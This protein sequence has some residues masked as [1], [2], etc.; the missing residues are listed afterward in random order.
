VRD[1]VGLNPQLAAASGA[2]GGQ[3]LNPDVIFPGQEITLPAASG[4]NIYSGGMGTNADTMAQIGRGNMPDSAITQRMA[5]RE[6]LKFV[7]LPVDRLI[8]RELTAMSWVVNES[9]YNTKHRGVWLTQAGTYAVFENIDRYRLALM[10]KTGVP[11]STRPEYYRPDMPDGPGKASK[12]GMIGRGLNWLDQKTK[13]V[14]GALSNFGHQFTTDV[15]KEKLKMNWH[16]AGKPSDSD[17]LATWL[18][19]QGVPQQV[20]SGVFKKM[21]IPYT[22]PQAAATTA[23]TTATTPAVAPQASAAPAPTTAPTTASQASAAIPPGEDPKGANYVGRREVA[24]RQAARAV[25]PQP[26]TTSTPN[27]GQQTAPYRYNAPATKAATA[28]TAP[29]APKIPKTATTDQQQQEYYR[30]LGLA[31][32]LEWSPTFNP[33]RSLYRQMKKES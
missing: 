29:P 23:P 3:M 11:G 9:V 2:K 32:N 28:S 27:F 6:S 10:E 26:T 24:R 33:G 4:E 25:A 30:A 19:T 15:T 1:I 20:V 13:A 31:E 8:D 5:M 21:S 14:G 12:P 16:Q 17:Q 22:P 7:T 18:V